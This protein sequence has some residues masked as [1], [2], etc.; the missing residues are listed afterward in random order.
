LRHESDRAVVRRQDP[1]LRI[2]RANAG[3]AR[4]CHPHG[5]DEEVRAHG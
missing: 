1:R 3:D 4:N 2:S 5:D